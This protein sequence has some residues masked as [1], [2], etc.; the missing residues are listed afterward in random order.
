MLRGS[1]HTVKPFEASYENGLLRPA[2][3]LPLNE[4]EHVQVVVMRKP[5]PARWDLAR[6]AATAADDTDLTE[7]GLDDWNSM[8][9]GED[10]R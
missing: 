7:A 10:A 1:L 4:G 8:L 3:P 5:D 9:D 2:K 6:I